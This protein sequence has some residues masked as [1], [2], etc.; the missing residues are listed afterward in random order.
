[1]LQSMG[2]QRVGH[3]W[4]TE[5]NWTE[6][7]FWKD[8]NPQRWGHDK[9]R[10][11]WHF[12]RW[13]ASVVLIWHIQ[14]SWEA[15]WPWRMVRLSLNYLQKPQKAQEY[16][17]KYLQ[18]GREQKWELVKSWLANITSL[19]P[20]PHFILRADCLS[21]N[22]G[23]I[24]EGLGG[25]VLFVSQR[26]KTERVSAMK[27]TRHSQGHGYFIDIKEIKAICI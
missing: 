2:S 12:G 18:K 15:S 17:I 10:A 26:N 5:L 21:P 8:L 6:R 13:K 24:K 22:P 16:G 11:Q 9:R 14:E 19:N 27:R 4:A 3:D 20:L 23:K 1:M 25:F 7:S